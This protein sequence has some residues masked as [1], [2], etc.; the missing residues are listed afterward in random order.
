M[1]SN[2]ITS[3][4]VNK[5]NK[6][7]FVDVVMSNHAKRR[8]IQREIKC[9]TYG[10]ASNIM[11]LGTQILSRINHEVCIIDKLNGFTIMCVI[12][13]KEHTNRLTVIIKTVIDKSDVFVMTGTDTIKI[14]H[15]F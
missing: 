6:L 11:A 14:E 1:K 15:L 9:N 5:D 8:Y 13:R 10:I 4:T 12:K 7:Y 2:I 3:Y